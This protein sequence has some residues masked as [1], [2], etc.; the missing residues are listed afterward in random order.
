MKGHAPIFLSEKCQDLLDLI[1]NAEVLHDDLMKGFWFDPLKN[2]PE[3]L[4]ELE[5]IHLDFFFLQFRFGL[6]GHQPDEDISV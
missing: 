4:E 2:L 5:K 1:L 3:S 6:R